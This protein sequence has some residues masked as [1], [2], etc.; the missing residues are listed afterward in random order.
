MCWVFV[1]VIVTGLVV[2][3]TLAW[4]VLIMMAVYY[5]PIDLGSVFGVLES[6]PDGWL[7]LSRW[8]QALTAVVQPEGFRDRRNLVVVAIAHPVQRPLFVCVA[9]PCRQNR[10]NEP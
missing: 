2:V 3:A 4:W 8:R 1:R 9:G 7:G 6:K 5:D 10:S